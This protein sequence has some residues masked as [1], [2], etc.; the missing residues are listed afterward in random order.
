MN[1]TVNGTLSGIGVGDSVTQI[2]IVWRLGAETA[3]Q[4]QAAGRG[5][6]LTSAGDISNFIGG[7][8]NLI[9]S[10]ATANTQYTPAVRITES[11]AGGGTQ[12]GAWTNGTAFTTAN[13]WWTNELDGTQLPSSLSPALTLMDPSPHTNTGAATALV[14]DGT[15]TM[16]IPSQTITNRVNTDN[17]GLYIWNT[18][19]IGA[20]NIGNEVE[21]RFKLNTASDMNFEIVILDGTKMLYTRIGK[22]IGSGTLRVES[23]P[24]SNWTLYATLNLDQYYVLRVASKLGQGIITLDGTTIWSGT[25]R[26]DSGYNM[27]FFGYETDKPTNSTYTIPLTEITIDYLRWKT[28]GTTLL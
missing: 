25:T 14:G 12:T 16:T 27:M 7:G 15:L 18:G 6:T 13:N 2:E 24:V 21:M 20:N 17:S 10:N 23:A 11:M 5:I 9:T 8:Y 3:D 4:A 22:G 26:S 28:N 19:A 1:A